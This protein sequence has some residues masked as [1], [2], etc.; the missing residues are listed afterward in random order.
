M[1]EGICFRLVGSK[2]KLFL[3][4]FFEYSNIFSSFNFV[5]QSF[6]IDMQF[7][8]KDVYKIAVYI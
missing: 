2:I 1:I 5:G 8:K 7:G 4:F 6:Q 3:H